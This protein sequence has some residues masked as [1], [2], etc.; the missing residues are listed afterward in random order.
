MFFQN[1][2]GT[3]FQSLSSDLGSIQHSSELTLHS[4]S[5]GDIDDADDRN[6]GSQNDDK[7]SKSICAAS[8]FKWSAGGQECEASHSSISVDIAAQNE[9]ITE[10]FDVTAPNKGKAS[11]RCIDNKIVLAADKIKSCVKDV[12][13][14]NPPPVLRPRMY[15]PSYYIL[16]QNKAIAYTG[17]T[18]SDIVYVCMQKSGSE[19]HCV[20]GNIEPH[21][22]EVSR[23]TA[24]N[25]PTQ[26]LLWESP[27]F[28][29]F[30]NFEF[31][32]YELYFYKK[33]AQGTRDFLG[34]TK[35]EIR[36]PESAVN[37]GTSGSYSSGTRTIHYKCAAGESNAVPS[38][39][40]T[41]IYTSLDCGYK[42]Q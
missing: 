17:A 15:Q 31:T 33:N 18:V 21:Y 3:N 36:L 29:A 8:T 14:T 1:C 11:I 30:D 42:V 19:Y 40:L 35:F 39:W 6:S 25:S 34:S 27:S 20:N 38:G 7:S 28:F 12:V 37:Q 23:P 24:P 9:N 16:T 32:D 2:S 41:Y 26:E 5:S 10:L 13:V 4:T 22:R